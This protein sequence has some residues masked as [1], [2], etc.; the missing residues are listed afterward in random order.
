M[1]KLSK[2]IPNQPL[3]RPLQHSNSARALVSDG[4]PHGKICGSLHEHWRWSTS[5]FWMAFCPRRC[6]RLDDPLRHLNL[7]TVYT[8][9]STGRHGWSWIILSTT[10]IWFSGELGHRQSLVRN[11]KMVLATPSRRWCGAQPVLLPKCREGL[12]WRRCCGT[13]EF[14]QRHFSMEQ[15]D[16]GIQVVQSVSDALHMFTHVY[17]CLH[18]HICIWSSRVSHAFFWYKLHQMCRSAGAESTQP[19]LGAGAAHPGLSLDMFGHRMTGN[20]KGPWAQYHRHKFQR[21]CLAYAAH[22]TTWFK[23]ACFSFFATD[24]SRS[25]AEGLCTTRIPFSWSAKEGMW[26]SFP[27][28]AKCPDVKVPPWIHHTEPGRGL[29]CQT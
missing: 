7:R 5:L 19:M 3:F 21:R 9:C 24:M 26:W 17:T 11:W 14:H 1:S 20:M 27:M 15:V 29:L 2:Q 12:T 28:M 6:A 23:P 10:C 25:D 16:I 8:F 13:L 22:A 4:G 18:I